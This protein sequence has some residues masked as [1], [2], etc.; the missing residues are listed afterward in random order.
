MISIG[1]PHTCIG[2]HGNVQHGNHDNQLTCISNHG[3]PHTCIACILAS[4][5]SSAPLILSLCSDV[6]PVLL[7]SCWMDS[8]SATIT[9]ALSPNMVLSPHREDWVTP[10]INICGGG[11][12]E[13][14]LASTSAPYTP[15][16]IS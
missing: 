8:S 4:M 16:V 13:W 3:N 6:T 7:D 12:V 1:Y 10:S 15:P 2:N 14:R 5:S 9:L 11:R